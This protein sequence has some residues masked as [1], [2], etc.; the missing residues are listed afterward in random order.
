MR[1]IRSLSSAT[2][3]L[4]FSSCAF[5]G[6]APSDAEFTDLPDGYGVRSSIFSSD[7][8]AM[9]AQ[10]KVAHFNTLGPFAR[11][12]L[13]ARKIIAAELTGGE[14]PN[15]LKMDAALA[16]YTKQ[17]QPDLMDN[18]NAML[19]IRAIMT[20]AQLADID[21]WNHPQEIALD[22]CRAPVELFLDRL[23]L[24]RGADLSPA[25]ST[26]LVALEAAAST[27]TGPLHAA[28]AA[29]NI[30]LQN[31]LHGPTA[32]LPAQLT[33]LVNQIADLQAQI[34][35]TNLDLAIQAVQLLT[36]AQRATAA[37]AHAKADPS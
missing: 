15:A 2:A 3:A 14:V 21:T 18:V 34:A 25:Q 11:A 12:D 7:Q 9:I 31:Q 27:T 37:V 6:T 5:A 35:Q 17:I 33:S 16:A 10:A 36:P 13:D 22:F 28:L 30:E 29:A 20:P 26:R 19:Q 24:S 8:L 4:I 1:L 23:G 32:P